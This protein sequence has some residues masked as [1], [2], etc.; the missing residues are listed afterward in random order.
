MI[1]K[2]KGEVT[3]RTEGSLYIRAGGISYE[4][5]VPRA[6]M[7]ALEDEGRLDGETELVTYHYLQITQSSGIPVLI[8]FQN[9]VEKEFFE[10]FISVSGIGPKAA[11][12]ALA[13]PFSVIA[14]AIDS[15]NEVFLKGLPGIGSR[16]A[17]EIV[18]KLKGSVGKYGLIRD[19]DIKVTRETH[20]IAEEAMAILLQLQYKKGEAEEMVNKALKRNPGMKSSEDLLNEVYREK[21]QR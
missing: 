16:K 1:A 13:E 5:L 9:S 11:C 18:A 10:K 6:V 14:G 8:G 12:K 3:D 4:V 17:A 20:G 2:I 19:E 21:A 7:S 15:G